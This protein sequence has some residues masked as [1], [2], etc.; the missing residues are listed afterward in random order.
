MSGIEVA[1]LALGAVPV[2]LETIKGY[3]TAYEHIQSLKQATRQLQIIDAQFRVCRINFL[4]EC[5]LLL[6]LVL[7][8]DPHLAKEMVADSQHRLWQDHR[9]EQRLASVLKDNADACT[10]IV[11]DTSATVKDFDARLSKLLSSSVSIS[12][13]SPSLQ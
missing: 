9:I 4:N 8:A 10:T 11:L 12:R 7:S 5:R 3:R 6:D 13:D 2:I 1:G